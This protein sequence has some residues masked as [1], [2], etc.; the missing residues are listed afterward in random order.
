MLWGDRIDVVTKTAG[1]WEVR[2]WTVEFGA[3]RVARLMIETPETVPPVAGKRRDRDGL[4]EIVSDN[5]RTAVDRARHNPT[6]SS[7]AHGHDPIR[8]QVA[9]S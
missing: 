8:S 2:Q 5:V 7:P 3:R 9:L 4:D 6:N 1:R